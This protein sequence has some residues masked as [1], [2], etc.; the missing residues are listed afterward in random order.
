M[1]TKKLYDH[2]SKEVNI[3]REVGYML[4][5]T[6]SMFEYSGLPETINPR[7]LEKMLQRSGYVFITEHEGKLYAFHG[8]TGGEL[9]AYYNPT[10]IIVNNPW[11]KLNKE[12]S[13]A[14]DG[15]FMRSDSMEMGLGQLYAKYCTMLVENDINMVM[16]GY[17]TRMQK[18]MSASDDKTRTSAEVFM[19]KLIDG[20]LSVIAENALFDGLKIHSEKSGSSDQ[21][22]SLIEYHQYIKATMMNEVGLASNFNMK[23][24]RFVAGEV[25]MQQ[26][27]AFP[28]VYDMMACRQ[29]AVKQINEKFGLSVEVGFGSVWAVNVKEFADGVAN[30]API[31]DGIQVTSTAP[32]GEAPIGDATAGGV[33]TEPLPAAKEEQVVAGDAV[34]PTQ[35]TQPTQTEQVD[36]VESKQVDKTSESDKSVVETETTT[37][38]EVITSKTDENGNPQTVIEETTQVVK[39]VSEVESEVKA[40]SESNEKV[41]ES[42]ETIGNPEGNPDASL[43]NPLDIVDPV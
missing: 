27:T 20:D 36:Q 34:Q 22:R 24:E 37:H 12:Y 4:A 6:I 17:N 8:G 13:I 28:L 11:L 23:R 42:D 14:D 26:D 40:V 1:A 43:D 39:Q 16:Y 21:V 35:T 2:R 25:E 29:E 19:R 18:M 9:D 15:V 30:N 3:N 7:E 5:K 38:T 10:K 32:V 31:L 41:S 33:T